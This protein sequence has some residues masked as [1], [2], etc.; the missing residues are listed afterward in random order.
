MKNFLPQKLTIYCGHCT[1]VVSQLG[2]LD[3]QQTIAIQMQKSCTVISVSMSYNGTAAGPTV[4]ST[5]A[6]QTVA[7]S[8]CKM[9]AS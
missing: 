4:A 8:G 1:V 7:E 5:I 3:T 2:K 9:A 6:S